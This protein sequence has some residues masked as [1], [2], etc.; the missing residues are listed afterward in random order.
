MKNTNEGKLERGIKYKSLKMAEIFK[1]R[2][3]GREQS[4]HLNEMCNM[5]IVKNLQTTRMK[6]K[7]QRI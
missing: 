6:K 5:K 7:V 4:V 2:R 1:K 3:K